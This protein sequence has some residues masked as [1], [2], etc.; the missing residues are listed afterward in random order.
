MRKATLVNV[1]KEDNQILLIFKEN[2]T[3]NEFTINYTG[4]LDLFDLNRLRG[5]TIEY[6]KNKKIGD[7]LR[8]SIKNVKD[9]IKSRFKKEKEKHDDYRNDER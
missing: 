4:K 5:C 6:E 8:D 9:R 2:N 7:D 3:E 1:I